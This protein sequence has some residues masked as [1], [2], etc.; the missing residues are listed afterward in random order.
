MPF[1]SVSLS[2]GVSL[3]PHE[4]V[5]DPLI[6]ACRRHV[7]GETVAVRVEAYFE[8]TLRFVQAP[9]RATHRLPERSVGPIEV[10]RLGPLGIANHE[11][12]LRPLLTPDVEFFLQ[13][14]MEID[15]AHRLFLATRLL[16]AA[17]V[18]EVLIKIDIHPAEPK[19]LAAPHSGVR[20]NCVEQVSVVERRVLAHG[21]QKPGDLFGTQVQAL[22]KVER[23]IV[24]K[25]PA[26]DDAYDLV[27]RAERRA[28]LI[29]VS[30]DAG[31]EVK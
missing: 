29:G 9:R 8:P 12:A 28:I 17:S 18:D 15:P 16:A 13:F 4:L 19:H 14:R 25:A 30:P 7:A 2:H 11:L 1:V 3:V 23:L 10:D 20:R 27:D 5:D 21:G 6:D 31:E 24:S 26:S 22:P